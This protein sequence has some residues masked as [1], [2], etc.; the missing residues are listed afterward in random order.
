MERLLVKGIQKI[1]MKMQQENKQCCTHVA[2]QIMMIM[3]L[4]ERTVLRQDSLF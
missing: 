1:S 3:I 4:Y 2:R